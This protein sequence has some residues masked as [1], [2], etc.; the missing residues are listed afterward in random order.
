MTFEC[1]SYANIENQ[2]VRYEWVYPPHLASSVVVEDQVLT[3][4]DVDSSAEVNFT[5]IVRLM[6]TGLISSADARIVIGEFW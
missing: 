2:S 3:V 5:C 6:G 1:L 4:E